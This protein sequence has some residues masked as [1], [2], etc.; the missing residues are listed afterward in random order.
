MCMFHLEIDFNTKQF[1]AVYLR[2]KQRVTF[3]VKCPLFHNY[4]S[5]MYNITLQ[6][7]LELPVKNDHFWK[8]V[9]YKYN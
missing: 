8:H 7:I 4:L 5:L 1:F 2:L 6:N 9:Y 3:E